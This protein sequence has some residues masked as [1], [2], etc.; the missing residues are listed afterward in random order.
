MPNVSNAYITSMGNYL[1]GPP[2]NNDEIESI[3]GM[4]NGKPSWLKSM[5]LKNNGIQTRHYALDKNQNTTHQNTEL[6][7]SAIRDCLKR[8]GMDS[9]EIDLL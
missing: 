9:S 2:I 3:L 4:I 7:A 5:V 1:P 6:A 8:V